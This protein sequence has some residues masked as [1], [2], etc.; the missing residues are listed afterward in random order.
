MLH[1]LYRIIY[2]VIVFILQMLSP[3]ISHL[4][5]SKG[6]SIRR[7]HHDGAGYQDSTHTVPSTPERYCAAVV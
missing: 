3:S 6:G 4:D 7:K 2:F 1:F 5:G